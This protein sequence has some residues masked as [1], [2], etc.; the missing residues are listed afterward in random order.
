MS[1]SETCIS[2]DICYLLAHDSTIHRFYMPGA[3]RIA[4]AVLNFLRLEFS[5]LAQDMEEEMRSRRKEEG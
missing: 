5:S 3:G 1:E 2:G 4:Y